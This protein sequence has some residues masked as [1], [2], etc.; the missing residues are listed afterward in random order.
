MM[1]YTDPYV[2]DE[3]YPYGDKKV[4]KIVWVIVAVAVVAVLLGLFFIRKKMRR[5]N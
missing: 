4:L 3:D 5:D 1:D 2:I